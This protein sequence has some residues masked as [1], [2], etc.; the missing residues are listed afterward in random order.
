V[1]LR[2]DRAMSSAGRWWTL[3]LG[4][5]TCALL[6]SCEFRETVVPLPVLE[7]VVSPSN[8]TLSLGATHQLAV[9]VKGEEGNSLGGR[10]V[11]WSSSNSSVATVNSSTGLVAGV[12]AGTATITATSEGR[13]GT[14]SVTV[15]AAPVPPSIQLSA[16]SRSFTAQAGSGNPGSQTVNITNGGGGTL[17]GLSAP[18]S[19]QGSQP[20]GWLNASLNTTTAPATLTLAVTTGSLVAGTYTATV[21]VTSGVANNSPQNVR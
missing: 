9:S 2:K 17:S 6:F 3:V 15:T 19:Y 11:S 8:V 10:A 16:T 18:V 4:G 20:T 13:S 7:V 12:G 5:W 14:A 1:I 21:A